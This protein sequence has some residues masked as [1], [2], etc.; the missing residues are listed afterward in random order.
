[1]GIPNPFY[2]VRFGGPVRAARG[3]NITSSRD[4]VNIMFV[5]VAC[6]AP[7]IDAMKW[8]YGKAIDVLTGYTPPNS[9]EMIL[10]AGLSYSKGIS[11][12]KPTKY[13]KDVN[14]TF[15]TDLTL[16]H[17][18]DILEAPRVSTQ[19]TRLLSR[20]LS[21]MTTAGITPSLTRSSRT[22][23]SL[24]AAARIV[25]SPRS[26]RSPRRLSGVSGR[27]KTS[28]TTRTSTRTPRRSSTTTAFSKSTT[29]TLRR[30]EHGYQ[31]AAG[32]RCDLRR[33]P[34]G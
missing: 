26:R 32:Q 19:S 33:V 16:N 25:V 15:R 13:L 2:V 18:L 22:F 20:S 5:T 3:K 23:P 14:F 10:E 11:T 27:T 9:G 28:T 21:T 4:H 24:L 8:L 12:V 30:T 7:T 17:S 1:N 31:D 29:T 34:G 6:M